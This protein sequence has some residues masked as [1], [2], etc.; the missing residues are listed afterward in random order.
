MEKKYD[1]AYKSE[2]KYDKTG[3]EEDY[4]NY[5][6]AGDELTN[7]NELYA[8]VIFNVLKMQKPLLHNYIDEKYDNGM[9]L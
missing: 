8:Q 1:N 5:M 6:L 9:M 4:K 3:K 7:Y 2:F